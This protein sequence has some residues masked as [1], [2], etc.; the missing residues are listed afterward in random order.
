[1]E[2]DRLDVIWVLVVDS[3]R[4]VPPEALPRFLLGAFNSSVRIVRLAVELLGRAAIIFSSRKSCGE[5]LS[6]TDC[7]VRR[8]RLIRW[9]FR[10]TKSWSRSTVPDPLAPT[11]TSR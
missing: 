8:H 1:M 5:N 2:L 9:T 6:V 4:L 3:S 7:Q 10:T 11:V